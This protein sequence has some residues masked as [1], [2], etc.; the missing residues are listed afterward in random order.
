MSILKC[1]NL[2]VVMMCHRHAKS[3]HSRAAAFGT[4]DCFGGNRLIWQSKGHVVL[5]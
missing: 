1:I 4:F 2:T 5:L 3:S